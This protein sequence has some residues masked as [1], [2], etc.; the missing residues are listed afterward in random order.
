M[1]PEKRLPDGEAHTVLTGMPF[2]SVS[3]GLGRFG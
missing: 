3:R 1:F 2:A